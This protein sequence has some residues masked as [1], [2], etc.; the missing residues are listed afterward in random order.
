MIEALV[1]PLLQLYVLAPPAVMVAFCSAQT[2]MLVTET[3]GGGP[4]T[5]VAVAT[6]GHPPGFVPDKVYVVL[7]TGAI[8]STGCGKYLLDGSS[9]NHDNKDK[10]ISFFTPKSSNKNVSYSSNNNH[11][12]NL[13]LVNNVEVNNDHKLSLRLSKEDIDPKMKSNTFFSKLGESKQKELKIVINNN[14]TFFIQRLILKLSKK[15]A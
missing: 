15:F 11:N 6:P 3:F 14:D 4:I 10:Q 7:I 13:L 2:V 5:T 8:I 12:S 9:N 1:P